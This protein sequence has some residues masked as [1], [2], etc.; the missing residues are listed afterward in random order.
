MQNKSS[1]IMSVLSHGEHYFEA[2]DV[3]FHY[4][5]HGQGPLLVVQSVGWGISST[6]LVRGLGPHLSQKHTTVY[7]EPRGNGK[8]SKPKDSNTMNAGKM[9]EDIEYLRKHLE[10]DSFPIL[11]GGS[12]SA[13]IVCRYAEIYPQKVSKLVLISP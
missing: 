1:I 11:L 10:L 8:S 2:D 12:H 4:Y 3:R 7:F 9:A 6:V 5:V 13:A